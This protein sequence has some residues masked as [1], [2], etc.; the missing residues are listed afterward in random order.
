MMY[1]YII[2]ICIYKF[3]ASMKHLSIILVFYSNKKINLSY[4]KYCKKKKMLVLWK[5]LQDYH[6]KK[7]LKNRTSIEINQNFS[8]ENS[9]IINN[10]LLHRTRLFFNTCITLLHFSYSS[11]YNLYNFILIKKSTNYSGKDLFPRIMQLIS[12]YRLQHL[13]SIK[14]IYTYIYI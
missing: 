4:N 11:L 1:V 9:S 2:Y 13:K 8:L 12:T 5:I 6:C 7:G 14:T 3:R 10:R